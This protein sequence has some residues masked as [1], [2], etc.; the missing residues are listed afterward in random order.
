M[1]NAA[2]GGLIRAAPVEVEVRSGG[3]GAWHVSDQQCRQASTLGGPANG[4]LL[5][6]TAPAP[7]TA[8]CFECWLEQAQYNAAN[9]TPTCWLA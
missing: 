3:R 6:L 9:T 7:A 8:F 2:I 5:Y 1:T 4:P